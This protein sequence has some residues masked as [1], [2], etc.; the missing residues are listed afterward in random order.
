[1][2]TGIVKSIG[3]VDTLKDDRLIISTDD[4][5]FINLEKGTSI[6]IDGCCL[7]LKDY[8]NNNLLFQ[9]SDETISRTSLNL[10]HCGFVNME[11]PLTAN[12]FLS[13]HIVQGHVDAVIKLENQKKSL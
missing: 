11:L 10:D 8:I 7:T 2:F 6:A 12:S 5:S 4:E 1:M 13:G 9:I 3:S